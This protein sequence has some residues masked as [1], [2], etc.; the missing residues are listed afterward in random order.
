[1]ACAAQRLNG[2]ALGQNN[3]TPDRAA[4]AGAG[5]SNFTM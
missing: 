5:F 4:L 2:V 3:D 1:M